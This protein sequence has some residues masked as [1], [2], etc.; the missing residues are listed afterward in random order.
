VPIASATIAAASPPPP[1]SSGSSLLPTHDYYTAAS[2]LHGRQT[3]AAMASDDNVD[4]LLSFIDFQLDQTEAAQL[5]KVRRV[6]M[7]WLDAA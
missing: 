7:T 2:P 6:L 4:L 5:L 1:S 3:T